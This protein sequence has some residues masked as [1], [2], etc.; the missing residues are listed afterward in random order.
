MVAINSSRDVEPREDPDTED[1]EIRMKRF[2]GHRT[3]FAGRS[4][5][6]HNCGARR[7]GISGLDIVV[8]TQAEYVADC[9]VSIVSPKFVRSLTVDNGS[10]ESRPALQDVFGHCGTSM[11]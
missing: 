6:C 7:S 9:K 8:L 1:T 10:E 11:R 2:V 3:G 5:G 4:D